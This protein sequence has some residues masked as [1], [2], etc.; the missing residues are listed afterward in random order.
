MSIGEKLGRVGCVYDFDDLEET[1]RKSR[2]RL[3]TII[4]HHNDQWQFDMNELVSKVRGLSDAC[5]IQARRDCLNV[6]M[7]K[8]FQ[9][10]VEEHTIFK[11]KVSEK[12]LLSF[13]TCKDS[14]LDLVPKESSK[15]GITREK[16]EDL[17]NLTKFMPASRRQFFENLLSSDVEDL[18][19]VQDIH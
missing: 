18:M 5:A 19:C 8:E 11:K 6:L 1:I 3:D 7:K 4:V 13:G 17:V 14:I 10:D 12:L 9:A 2:K 15:R 16:K